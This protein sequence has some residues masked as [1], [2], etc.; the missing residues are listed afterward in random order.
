MA[1]QKRIRDKKIIAAPP[2]YVNPFT[3]RRFLQA[4]TSAPSKSALQIA[5]HMAIRL[6]PSNS[7]EPLPISSCGLNAVDLAD[8]QLQIN[9]LR[10][11]A[12]LMEPSPERNQLLLQAACLINE[13]KPF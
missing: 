5:T 9:E 12:K 3:L 2:A 11:L 13:K 1:V 6:I 10:E 7:V 8:L 4:V